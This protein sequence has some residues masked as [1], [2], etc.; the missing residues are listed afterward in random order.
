MDGNSSLRY[1]QR[2]NL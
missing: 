2:Q 1:S